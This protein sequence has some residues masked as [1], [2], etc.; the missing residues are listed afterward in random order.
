MNRE[1]LH[2]R[3]TEL[4]E[5]CGTDPDTLPIAGILSALL[6]AMVE[7]QERALLHVCADFSR[8]QISAIVGARQ[9][10]N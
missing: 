3:L 6:G 1:E 9:R 7:R 8:A 2:E 10:R 5:E 4:A